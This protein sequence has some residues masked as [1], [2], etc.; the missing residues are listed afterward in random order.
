MY[1]PTFALSNEKIISSITYIMKSRIYKKKGFVYVD[2][3]QTT[4]LPHVDKRRHL[5]D[6]PPTSSCL[7]SYWMPPNGM[8]VI[9]FN[10]LW[11]DETLKVNAS[12]K[13]TSK[14]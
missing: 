7:R 12:I 10:I 14:I 11:K 8:W 1:L 3:E 6:H 9:I 2:I 5:A 4:Y 13:N